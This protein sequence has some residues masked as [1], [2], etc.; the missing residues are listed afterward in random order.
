MTF[1]THQLNSGSLSCLNDIVASATSMVFDSLISERGIQLVD[2]SFQRTL[3]Y[4]PLVVITG[5]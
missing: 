3:A 5:A 4:Q 1:R 2:L